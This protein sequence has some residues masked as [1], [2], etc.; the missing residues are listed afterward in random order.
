M[1]P[2]GQ[3][4]ERGYQQKRMGIMAARKSVLCQF[5]K[6]FWPEVIEEENGPLQ[7]RPFAKKL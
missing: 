6:R 4:P 3:L 5:R 1:H 7:Q 2:T